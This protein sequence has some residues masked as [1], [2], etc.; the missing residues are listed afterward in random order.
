MCPCFLYM[1]VV[2]SGLSHFQYVG[3]R[4]NANEC[5]QNSEMLVGTEI[6]ASTLHSIWQI[7]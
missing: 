7:R 5:G 6:L 4:L 2:N 3:E 1:D